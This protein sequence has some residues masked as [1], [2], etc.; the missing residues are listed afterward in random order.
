MTLFKAT[1]FSSLFPRL[2]ASKLLTLLIL[3]SA[4][5]AKAATQTQQASTQQSFLQQ[6][7]QTINSLK[8]YIN[9]YGQEF[10]QGWGELNSQL[11][12]IISS[13]IGDLGIPDPLK[14]GKQISQ[15]IGQQQPDL[16]TIDPGLQGDDAERSWHQQ[17]T[18]GQS[19]SILGT[20]GQ[21]VQ[22]Q[23]AETSNNALATSSN[24]ADAAQNDIVTQDILKKI[25]IQNSQAAIINKSI[26]GEAQKQTQALAAANINLADISGQMDLQA[27]RQQ[28][29]DISSAKQILNAA[30]FADGFW[31]KR[32]K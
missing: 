20:E 9:Q 30:A 6:V 32:K 26:Q 28:N 17:Y 14:S 31:E 12:Q 19:Q 13:S 11:N 27:R 18:L 22:S 23:E 29:E 10:S 24:N 3:T 4:Y 1:I 2:V 15:V 16:L 8:T 21:K 5:P 7:Q 25:A